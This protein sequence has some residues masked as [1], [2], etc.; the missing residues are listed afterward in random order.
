MTTVPQKGPRV[1][2]HTLRTNVV[3]R[4]F[5][6]VT[7][8]WASKWSRSGGMLTSRS[9]VMRPPKLPGRRAGTR[10]LTKTTAPAAGE[11]K[12]HPN[13]PCMNHPCSSPAGDSGSRAR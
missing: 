4:P 12:I 5:A 8:I 11:T 6:L 9:E 3:F 13:R 10:L 1:C 2:S 7:F